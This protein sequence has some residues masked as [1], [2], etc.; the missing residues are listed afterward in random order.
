MQM[1]FGLRFYRKL[2]TK[3]LIIFQ[4]DH[5]ITLKSAVKHATKI[6]GDVISVDPQLLFQRLGPLSDQS[7]TLKEKKEPFK[8]DL[9]GYPTSLF[10]TGHFL[11]HGNKA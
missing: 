7:S 1:K 11:R 2:S 3:Q 9:S 5:A 4:S 10:D 8:Y 6:E